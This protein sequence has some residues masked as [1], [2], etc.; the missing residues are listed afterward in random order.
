MIRG[1]NGKQECQDFVQAHSM[2][3]N[4]SNVEVPVPDP[5]TV[6]NSEEVGDPFPMKEL[7]VITVSLL[8]RLLPPSSRTHLLDEIQS[9]A[10]LVKI[11]QR[12]KCLLVG[13][14]PQGGGTI[15]L[16]NQ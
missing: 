16:R 13:T 1:R 11:K 6:T 9:G 2:T 10:E 12:S 5:N 3:I 4:R 15:A 7:W 14:R 8:G